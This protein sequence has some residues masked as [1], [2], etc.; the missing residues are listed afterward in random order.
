[1]AVLSIFYD[2]DVLKF[3]LAGPLNTALSQFGTRA[4]RLSEILASLNSDPNSSNSQALPHPTDCMEL[5]ELEPVL[6]RTA[7][8]RGLKKNTSSRSDNVSTLN[9]LYDFHFLRRRLSGRLND[10]YGVPVYHI[11]TTRGVLGS[12]KSTTVTRAATGEIIAEV[13]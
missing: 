8:S 1:M 5:G 13:Q 2:S 11:R 3:P 10:P 7:R 9:Y 6:Q 12:I 4:N